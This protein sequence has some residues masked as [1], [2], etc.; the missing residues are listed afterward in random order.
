MNLRVVGAGLPRTGTSSLKTALEQLIG[1]RCYHMSVLPGHPF[2]LGVDWNQALA[3]N[4]PDW[5]RVFDGY[6]A[7]VDWPASLFWRELS[8]AN[9]DALVLLSVRNSAEAWWHSADD[10]I[11]PFARMAAYERHNAEVRASVPQQRL[12]E[13]HAPEG[14]API[15]HALGVPVPDQPFPWNNRRSDWT[16]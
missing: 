4:M 6:V 16:K 8:A 13:W 2:D 10:T 1:G 5:E 3:G 14:W 15:C 9:P 12:L 7:A 11:L